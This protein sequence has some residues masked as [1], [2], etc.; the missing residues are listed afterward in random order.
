MFVVYGGIVHFL[1]GLYSRR[2]PFTWR[3][4][5]LRLKEVPFLKNLYAG[6]F[7]SLLLILTPYLYVQQTPGLVAALAV[8]G[9]FGMNYFTEVLWDVRDMPGDAKAGFRTVPMVIGLPATYRL[10]LAVHVLTC[11]VVLGGAL[12]GLLP[13]GFLWVGAAHLPIGWWLLNRYW[14]LPDK[15]WASHLYLVY[16]GILL[17]SGMA[18]TWALERGGWA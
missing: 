16:A 4:R 15:E 7:W 9:S 10:L 11:G 13:V 8:V 3:G 18:L 1:G 14:Q 6:I 17:S 12:A 2:L 5:P